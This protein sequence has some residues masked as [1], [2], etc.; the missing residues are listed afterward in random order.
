MHGDDPL[1]VDCCYIVKATI[2]RHAH[3]DYEDHDE[4]H[5]NRLRILNKIG[6]KKENE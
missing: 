4:N 2:K 3:N 1:E 6:I 5:I